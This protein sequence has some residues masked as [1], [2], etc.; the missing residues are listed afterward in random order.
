[1][2]HDYLTGRHIPISYDGRVLT[3]E[4]RRVLGT[5]GAGQHLEVWLDAHGEMIYP[6]IP[7]DDPR[8][9]EEYTYDR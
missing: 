6:V 3:G 5:S 2:T 7:A 9:S 1:M 8:L 4:I